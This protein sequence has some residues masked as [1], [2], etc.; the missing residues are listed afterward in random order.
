DVN[1]KESFELKVF[2]NLGREIY[3]ESLGP[4][5]GV[6]KYQLDL[7]AFS[8]GIYNLHLITSKGVMSRQVLIK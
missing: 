1:Q 3:R 7:S 2:D 4:F 6:T 5:N 8:V